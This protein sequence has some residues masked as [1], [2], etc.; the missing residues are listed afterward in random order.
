MQ[1]FYFRSHFLPRN[2]ALKQV[3]S[4]M[5]SVKRC[6]VWSNRNPISVR[7]ISVC[8]VQ[9]QKP[10]L[11]CKQQLKSLLF[12]FFVFFYVLLPLSISGGLTASEFFSHWSQSMKKLLCKLFACCIYPVM[13]F[14]CHKYANKN[15]NLE[16]ENV[17][18]K[19]PDLL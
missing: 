14:G 2:P 3:L 7:I 1:F 8:F 10:C 5:Y 13:L 17:Q 6:S 9:S 19:S 12:F 16:F 4:D 18:N 11:L 15:I